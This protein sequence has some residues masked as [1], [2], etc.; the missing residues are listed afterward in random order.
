MEG[1]GKEGRKWALVQAG[2]QSTWQ[3]WRQWIPTECM[4]INVTQQQNH[5]RWGDKY[6][7]HIFFLQ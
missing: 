6:A 7:S 4:E 5:E 2:I 3:D 1:E